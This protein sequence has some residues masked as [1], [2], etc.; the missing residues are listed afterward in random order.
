VNPEKGPNGAQ[1]KADEAK[2]RRQ[3]NWDAWVTRRE[4]DEE[5][6]IRSSLP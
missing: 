2:K 1:Q 5:R 6:L 4:K 3:R